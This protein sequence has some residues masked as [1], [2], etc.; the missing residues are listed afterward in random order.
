M[1]SK[2]EETLTP[3]EEKKN[4]HFS[5]LV[6]IFIGMAIIILITILSLVIH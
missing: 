5:F 6:G 3:E 2:T 4:N 1:M